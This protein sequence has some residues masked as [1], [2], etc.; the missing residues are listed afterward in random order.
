MKIIRTANYK[1]LAQTGPENSQPIPT[2]NNIQESTNTNLNS[3]FEE[4]SQQE[5]LPGMGDG[6]SVHIVVDAQN[7]EAASVEHND[8]NEPYVELYDKNV[9]VN[10]PNKNTRNGETFI[11]VE[12]LN[13]TSGNSEVTIFL[14]APSIIQTL[15]QNIH[16]EE[17]MW[18]LDLIKQ[19][20]ITGK[21]DEQGDAFKR[22]VV[23][24]LPYIKAPIGKY[25]DVSTQ[26]IKVPD[27]F[28]WWNGFVVIYYN[29]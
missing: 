10:P 1:K 14:I 15:K 2:Q 11:N 4:V 12:N 25:G 29:Y 22:D 9:N 24:K 18:S 17:K 20:F 21:G 27:S 5:V 13:L 6:Y 26:S 3:F 28:S 23:S 19:L 8:P 7:P 16:Q